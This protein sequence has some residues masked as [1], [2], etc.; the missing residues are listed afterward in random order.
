LLDKSYIFNI[1]ILN[2]RIYNI[3]NKNE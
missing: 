3:I 2:I 1:S